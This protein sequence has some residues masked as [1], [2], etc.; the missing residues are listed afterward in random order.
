FFSKE[1]DL[2]DL[3]KYTFEDVF[4]KIYPKGKIYSIR[5]DGTYYTKSGLLRGQY[6]LRNY[7]DFHNNVGRENFTGFNALRK[8]LSVETHEYFQTLIN[9]AEY[10]FFPYM[11][12]FHVSWKLGLYFIFIPDTPHKY[13]LGKFPQDILSFIRSEVKIADN[14]K[15]EEINEINIFS[16]HNF[17][18]PAL[19]EYTDFFE[20]FLIKSEKFISFNFNLCNFV[21]EDDADVIDPIFAYEYNLSLLHMLKM[22]LSILSSNDSYYNKSTTFLIADMLDGI[23]SKVSIGIPRNG[24]EFF[25]RLF[26]RDFAVNKFNEIMTNSPL[27]IKEYLKSVNE[28]I[29]TQIVDT[30]KESVWLKYKVSG[31]NITVRNNTL[32]GDNVENVVDFT[33]NV[34]R[35]LRNT[36]HGYFTRN[37]RRGMRPSRYLSMITGV[38]PSTISSLS[39]FWVLLLLEDRETFIGNIV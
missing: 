2:K 32:T 1:N 36:H 19:D 28:D 7:P 21:S 8:W 11:C 3:L 14:L 39:F 6:T 12:S 31:D 23:C 25:K 5:M 35:A 4:L 9:I 24:S 29:Y 16:K 30:V 15:L 18:C 33:S 34:I 26:N 37:D 13:E 38:L 27:R 20:W 17:P 22:S 10:F